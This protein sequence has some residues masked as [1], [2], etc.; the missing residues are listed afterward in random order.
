[1]PSVIVSEALLHQQLWESAGHQ[2]QISHLFRDFFGCVV[3][4][5]HGVNLCKLHEAAV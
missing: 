3:H 2:L 5:V 1:M 4:S